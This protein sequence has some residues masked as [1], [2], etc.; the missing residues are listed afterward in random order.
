MANNSNRSFRVPVTVG[1]EVEVELDAA[2]IDA[3]VKHPVVITSLEHGQA[4]TVSP[5]AK[6]EGKMPIKRRAFHTRNYNAKQEIKEQIERLFLY[7]NGA[8]ASVDVLNHLA[9]LGYAS[10]TISK[11]KE[12]MKI[13]SEWRNG[14]RHWVLKGR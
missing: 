8:V 11:V 13:R 12:E 10:S 7:A 3:T 5:K 9:D 4:T 1:L 6:R 2:F 14:V